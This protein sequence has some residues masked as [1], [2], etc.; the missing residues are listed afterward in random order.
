MRWAERRQL[1]RT[2]RRLV[3][4]KDSSTLSGSP[5]MGP[6]DVSGLAA[7]T[8]LEELTVRRVTPSSL[9]CLGSSS[10]SLTR[11]ELGPDYTLGHQEYNEQGL[12]SDATAVEAACAVTS[13]RHLVLTV[14][15]TGLPNSIS[16]LQQLSRL[17]IR[18]VGS[19][20]AGFR[21]LPSDLGTRLPRLVWLEVTPGA[22]SGDPCQL[23]AVPASLSRLS[24]LDLNCSR[25]YPGPWPHGTITL[26]ATLAGAL[27][28]L[29]LTSCNLATVHGLSRLTGLEL[30][31]LTKAKVIGS[32]LTALRPLTRLRHLAFEHTWTNDGYPDPSTFT[33]FGT[34]QHLTSITA[35]GGSTACWQA[36]VSAAPPPGLKQLCLAAKDNS[37]ALAA[38]S[39]WLSQATA[40]TKLS[41]GGRAVSHAQEV[42][43]LP[44]SLVELELGCVEWAEGH[45]PR[46][47]LRLTALEVLHVRVPEGGL[48]TWFTK[49]RRLEGLGLWSADRLRQTG[50]HLL[51]ALPALRALRF[52]DRGGWDQTV[53]YDHRNLAVSVWQ[54]GSYLPGDW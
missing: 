13:L 41:L 23:E 49:L 2:L 32:S 43:C 34:L 28:E 31:V 25:N 52:K 46:G 29:H 36:L 9:Q 38:L 7:A 44:P 20:A 10:S 3:L 6:V 47:L 37:S 48:P 42:L 26:P 8:G 16:A 17:H 51:A 18:A 1:S 14:P 33:I 22:S 53:P 5:P 27:K 45:L 12:L 15:P 19:G 4:N 21:E 50:L 11:L 24:R 54:Q 30:L 40:L 39:P 35:T